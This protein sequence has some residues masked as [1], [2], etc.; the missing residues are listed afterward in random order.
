[1][2]TI[3]HLNNSHSHV[4]LWLMEELGLP[5]E[6]VK[7]Q[8]D[9]ETM[10]SPPSLRA[11]HP[12]AKAPTIEDHGIAMIESAG[13]ILYILDACGQGRLRPAPNTPEAMRFFQLLTYTEG[14][15]KALLT[16]YLSLLGSAPDDPVRVASER[17]A[18]TALK[19]I[20]S[21]LQGQDTI[22]A[23][24]FTAADIQLGFFEEIMDGVGQI[25][26][27]PNMHA[28]LQRMRLREGYRR[29]E[30]K[31]GP[32]ALRSLFGSRMRAAS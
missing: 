22:V 5:Y 24:M 11:I 20:E 14:S 10:L 2:I 32:V 13:I 29:A 31:G 19:V 9:A 16:Q 8:R 26:A 1:M 23:G 7:H 28:H 17:S 18:T 12:A 6:L 25:E 4:A 30:A 15:V 27:W 3:H 21:A